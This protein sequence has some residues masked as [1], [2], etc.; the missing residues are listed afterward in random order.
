MANELLTK[1]SQKS[2][3]FLKKNSSLLFSLGCSAGVLATGFTSARAA[4][5]ARQ[6]LLLTE[7]V[8]D[9]TLTTKETLF[10][11]APYYILPFTIAGV[12]IGGIFC[13]HTL[14]QKEKLALISA[15]AL[16]TSKLEE[17]KEKVNEIY[18][19]NATKMVTDAINEEKASIQ[20]PPFKKPETKLFYEPISGRLIER[21]EVEVLEAEYHFNRNFILR[22]YAKLN[23]F[24]D[25]LGLERTP[26]GDVLGWSLDAGAEFYGYSWIDFDHEEHT[27]MDG[28]EITDIVMPFSPTADYLLDFCG[29]PI[30]TPISFSNSQNLQTI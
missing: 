17:F 30:D 8:K 16:M 11:A 9:D 7:E 22:G 23:E 20:A 3:T 12:T 28:L 5:K 14:N 26:E 18:G 29:E 21:T 6:K 4:L 1:I 13:N 10:I 27:T 15:C 2:C 25:F 24:Y 19:E